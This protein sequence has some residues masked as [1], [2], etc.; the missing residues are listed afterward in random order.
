M[1]GNVFGIAIIMKIF[2]FS[3]V[4]HKQGFGQEKLMIYMKRKD[5]HK[6][7]KAYYKRQILFETNQTLA[8]GQKRVKWGWF[9]KGF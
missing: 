6:D 1:K 7:F 4:Q 3:Y 2:P 8:S 5:G 9:N